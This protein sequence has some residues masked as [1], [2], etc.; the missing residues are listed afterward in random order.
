MTHTRKKRNGGLGNNIF[1]TN[2]I[3]TQPNMDPSYKEMGIIHFT[4]SGAVNA[5]RQ[6]LTGLV[7]IVGQK[8]FENTIYDQIRNKALDTFSKKIANNQKVA[9]VRMDIETDAMN[10]ILIHI[11]GTLLQ[12][13]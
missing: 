11:Y 5:V 2:K 4:D 9:N 12:R 10:K 1:I 3:S 6:G 7:N 8:G 13:G